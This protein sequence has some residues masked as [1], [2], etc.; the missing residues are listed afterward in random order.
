MFDS[1][2]NA[3]RALDEALRC[4]EPEV[5]SGAEARAALADVIRGERL[6]AAAKVAL[7][8]W[9]DRSGA[10]QGTGSRSGSD[11][12]AK[13]AGTSKAAARKSLDNAAA[14]ENLPATKEAFTKG[15]ISEPHA[16][17]VA[18]AAADNPEAEADLLETARTQDLVALRDKARK[19]REAAEDRDARHQRQHAAREFKH[20]IDDDGMVNGRFRLPPEVGEPI[21][22][23]IEAETDRIFRQSYREGRREPRKA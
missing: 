10:Y 19:V 22:N 1:T 15:E 6:C 21:I 17:A 16:E 3:V 2:H 11:L 23:R 8:A 5:L 13:E 9:I 18:R 12:L 7:A 4:L 14:L 20:F